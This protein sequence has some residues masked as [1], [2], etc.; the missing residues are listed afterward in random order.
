M[1]RMVFIFTLEKHF[2]LW[3]MPMAYVLYVCYC[4]VLPSNLCGACSASS[5]SRLISAFHSQNVTTVLDI[6]WMP[7]WIDPGFGSIWS[8]TLRNRDQANRFILFFDIGCLA[9]CIAS[10]LPECYMAPYVKPACSKIQWKKSVSSV[11][12]FRF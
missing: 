10:L 8:N 11:L 12:R 2:T 1:Y 7:V 5:F 3:I 4:Q 9:F 6:F